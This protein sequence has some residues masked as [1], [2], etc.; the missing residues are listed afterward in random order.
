[1]KTQNKLTVAECIEQICGY[2]DFPE[3]GGNA[4]VEINGNGWVLS[5]CEGSQCWWDGAPTYR[6]LMDSEFASV[7][8]TDEEDIEDEEEKVKELDINADFIRAA[9]AV[10]NAE[11]EKYDATMLTRRIDTIVESVEGMKVYC[12]YPRDFANEFSLVVDEE[13]EDEPLTREQLETILEN[14]LTDETH[15][16]ALLSEYDTYSPN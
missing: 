10:C 6:E 11:E 7:L 8:V 2:H 4:S 9:H 1:M 13:R 15:Y 5:A 12:D 16:G 3:C 14:W